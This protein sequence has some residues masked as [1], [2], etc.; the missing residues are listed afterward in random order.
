MRLLLVSAAVLL[1]GCM[2]S[3]GKPEHAGKANPILGDAIAVTKLDA[4]ATQGPAPSPASGPA[5]GAVSAVPQ[6]DPKPGTVAPKAEP[7][8]KPEES[9]VISPEESSCTKHGGAWS[10]AGFEGS[11]ACVHLTKDAGKSCRKES[12]C[13]GYCLARSGTCAPAKPMF[14]CND[15]LQDNGVMVTLCID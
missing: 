9:R 11:M 15:I 8:A 6:E 3:P 10:G 14:G 13:E 1:A 12:D 5:E 7:A 4:A 2:F